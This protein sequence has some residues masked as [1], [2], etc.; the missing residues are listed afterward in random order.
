ML[1]GKEVRLN[2]LLDPES[3]RFVGITVDHA[4]ARGVLPGLTNIRETVAKVAAG[5]P[6]AITMHKGIAEMVFPPYAGRIPLIL[7]ATTFAPYHTNYDTPVADVEEAIRLG[8]DAISVGVIV[9]GP[10]QAQQLS[11]LARISKEAAAA[12]LP[13]VTHIYPRGSQVPDPKDANAVAYA[14][15]AGAELGA[16][17]IKT[18]WTGSADSFAKVI[19]A[20][21]ARVVIAGGSPG[22]DLESY[23]RM[24]W[25]GIQAGMAGVTYG[26]FVWQ[27][28]N[29]A[30][31]IAALK[32]IVH[33][34]A[35]VKEALQVYR[36]AAEKR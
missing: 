20:C 27:D 29:P 19:A 7:K 25:E 18:N 6:N 21:P 34:G 8:A 9:G 28:A 11:Y 22:N 4:M 10:E 13:L 3:G 23:L 2:R 24:T 12:G 31:V 36:E 26:R 17:I 1:L 5:R 14:V 16:D 15:R 35:S 30:A 33:H 32:A